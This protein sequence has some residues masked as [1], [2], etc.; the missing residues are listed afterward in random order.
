MKQRRPLHVPIVCEGFKPLGAINA[1]VD[2]LALLEG[3]E[4]QGSLLERL[5]HGNWISMTVMHDA[6]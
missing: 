2:L 4:Y 6:Q 5:R 1:R 3:S